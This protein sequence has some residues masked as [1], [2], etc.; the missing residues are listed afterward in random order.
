MDKHN[1]IVGSVN[2]TGGMSVAPQGTPLPEAVRSKL[3]AAFRNF[4]YLTSDGFEREEKV[5]TTNLTA[6]G[7]DTV[8]I[9]KKGT[10]VTLT[11]DYMEYNNE[12][13]QKAI[14]GDKNVKVTAASSDHGRQTTI[15]GVVDLQGEHVLVVDLVDTDGQDVRW[16]FGAA[17]I[18]SRDKYTAQD[19]KALSRKVTWNLYPMGFTDEGKPYYFVEYTDDNVRQGVAAQEG[20]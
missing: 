2:A 20:K 10:T 5:D 11:C 17:E 12:V 18:T 3:D 4:G 13:V 9:V 14:Y 7:G 19:E 6:L 15:Y 1:V 16:V 8:K